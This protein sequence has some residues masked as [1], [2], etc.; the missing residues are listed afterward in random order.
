[1]SDESVHDRDGIWQQLRRRK[2]VQWGIAYAA[3]GWAFLQGLEYVGEAFGWPGAIRQVAIL[4][5]MVGLPFVIMV[6][7]YHGGRGR[8]RVTGTEVTMLAL[9]AAAGVL[10]IVAAT[11]AWL[12]SRSGFAG[13]DPLADVRYSTLT[14]FEGIEQAAAI[15]RDGKFAAFLSNH[16]GPMDA[17]VTQI[18][19]GEFHNLTRGELPELF[20][21]EVRNVEFTPD[22]TQ[23]TLW[24]RTSGREDDQRRID[25]W[26]V[27]TMGGTPR[28]ILPGVVELAWSGDGARLAYHTA[29]PGDPI[30]V[31]DAGETVGRRTYAAPA[32]THC[33]YPTWSPDDEYI[34]FVRGTPPDVMDIWRVR[35]DGTDAE[36][37]TFHASRVTHPVFVG[38]R[39][40]IYLATSDDGLGPWP[41]VLDTRRRESRRVH[42]GTDR[43]KSLS[44]SADGR[45]L[46]ATVVRPMS[47]LWRLPVADGVT[48]ESAASR[49][50]LPTTAAR[51]PR[52]GPGYLLYVSSKRG[53]EGIWKLAGDDATELWSRPKTRLVG[54]PAISP[55]GRHIAFTAERNGESRLHVM[56]ADGIGAQVLASA[57]EVHGS[58]TWAHDGQSITV[59]ALEEG[60]PRIISV[61][62]DGRTPVQLVHHYATEPNW[63]P[64]GEFL[65]YTGPQVGVNVDVRAVTADGRPRTLPQ[66]TLTRG[67]ERMAILRDGEAMVVLRGEI[68]NRNLVV[69]D[70]E[71]GIERK[72]TSFGRNVTVGDF[73][74]S[75]GGN[76]IV[77]ERRAESADILMIER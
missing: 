71:S 20:N 59:S 73:D 38:R 69:F 23:V 25:V 14:D 34:Y 12:L 67:A 49:I 26:S 41:H 33:H 19:S 31:T 32:G 48:D 7:W 57:L 77:F 74:V 16:D 9:L 24:A 76:E 36:R 62:L 4:V 6:A 3:A 46:L 45:R 55:D 29:E 58:P 52:Y 30:Y 44:A 17:W 15:S 60:E 5:V 1:M 28:P 40:L 54:A 22:G 65:V 75:G 47:T 11:S 37:M 51:S 50:A 53:Q 27:P 2:V 10:F 42:I 39:T 61:P 66:L 8:Q 72:L 43:Y 70:L 68:G 18:G 13:Q 56:D 35:T 21:D 63:S 64:T